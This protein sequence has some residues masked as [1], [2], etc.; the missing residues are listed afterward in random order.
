MNSILLYSVLALL[1][2][3]KVYYFTIDKYFA[4]YS[5]KDIGLASSE[6]TDIL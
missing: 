1:N 2:K 4:N 6:G 3:L 5:L